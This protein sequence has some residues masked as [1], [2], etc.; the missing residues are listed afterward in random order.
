MR[1]IAALF[2]PYAPEALPSH[3]SVFSHDF[4]RFERLT[5][6]ATS[7]EFVDGCSESINRGVR[8]SEALLF[9]R[10]ELKNDEEMHSV[11]ASMYALQTAIN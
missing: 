6:L 8:L 4:K 7:S 11:S 2:G 10:D 3:V 1:V 5:K 9:A